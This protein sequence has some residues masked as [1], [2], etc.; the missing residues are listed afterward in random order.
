[1]ELRLYLAAL[2]ATS[3]EVERV[4]VMLLSMVA[5][6]PSVSSAPGGLCSLSHW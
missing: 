5:G 1:V 6:D 3:A 2:A 4:A